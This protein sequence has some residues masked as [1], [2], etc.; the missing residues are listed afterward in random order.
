ML[1]IYQLIWYVYISVCVCVCVCMYVWFVCM[2]ISVSVRKRVRMCV[3]L[4]IYVCMYVYMYTYMYG[5]VCNLC[6]RSQPHRIFWSIIFNYG[7]PKLKHQVRQFSNSACK[8]SPHL[9]QHL[10]ALASF[11]QAYN[12]TVTCTSSALALLLPY[13]CPISR[14]HAY[15]MWSYCTQ[16]FG[17]YTNLFGPPAGLRVVRGTYW[18]QNCYKS[19]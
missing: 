10:T 15:I 7:L 5:C 14:S 19:K 3:C 2:Y 6:M 17:L 8:Y 16:I 1:L 13:Y 9:V 11:H 18:Q 4:C 12:K